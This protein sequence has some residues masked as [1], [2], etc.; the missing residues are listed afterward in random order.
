MIY[1]SLKI[2]LLF[3]KLEKSISKSNNH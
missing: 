3:Y 2:S 1:Q